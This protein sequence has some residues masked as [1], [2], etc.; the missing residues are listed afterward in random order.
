[1]TLTPKLELKWKHLKKQEL[2]RKVFKPKKKLFFSIV[3]F[4]K[5]KKIAEFNKKINKKKGYL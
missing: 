2:E 5:H 3:I 1:M 4:K